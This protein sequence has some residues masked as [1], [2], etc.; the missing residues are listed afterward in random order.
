M[1]VAI[2]P[3][4]QELRRDGELV[5]H[6]LSH[7]AYVIKVRRFSNAVFCWVWEAASL[8]T[9][10]IGSEIGR[11]IKEELPPALV[12]AAGFAAGT[13]WQLDIPAAVP[14]LTEPVCDATRSHLSMPRAAKFNSSKL[15]LRG[16]DK[17]LIN[18]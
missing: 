2:A 16:Q 12:P 5:V 3:I 10:G 11:A 4:L 14:G 8:A 1:S 17:S 15:L 13:T 9:S 7:E 18:S 6:N